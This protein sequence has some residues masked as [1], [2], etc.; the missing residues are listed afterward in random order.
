MI[1]LWR[2]E[3]LIWGLFFPLFQI[4][5][6][7][8]KNL[9]ERY[10]QEIALNNSVRLEE[11]E[12]TIQISSE[13]E[14]EQAM[15]LLENLLTR[16]KKVQLMISSSSVLKKA[17]AL[18]EKYPELDLKMVPLVSYFWQKTP[19][20]SN[21]S[22]FLSP[23]HLILCRYDFF[24]FLMLW[25]AKPSVK[26]SLISASLKGK[27]MNF[28]GGMSKLYWN[29]LYSFF[30]FII[31]ASPQ[32]QKRFCDLI[33]S[34]QGADFDFRQLR[35]LS[36]LDQAPLKLG[37]WKGLKVFQSYLDQFKKENRIIL[38]S[39]WSEECSVLQNP[40]FLKD[41]GLRKCCLV[42]APHKLNDE[43]ILKLKQ[44]IYTYC[45]AYEEKISVEEIGE[46]PLTGQPLKAPVIIV[47]K[48]GILV[49][50]YQYFAHAYIGG[51][52]G[53]SIHSVLEPFLAGCRVYCGPKTHRST[54][55]DLV[56]SHGDD[57]IQVIQDPSYFY[58]FYLKNKTVNISKKE[59]LISHLKQ[60]EVIH[61]KRLIG[62]A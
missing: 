29:S 1:I 8:F 3:L 21:P 28:L 5:R 35:I 23:H 10:S 52:H 44:R 34:F 62:E 11:N 31:P 48:P 36:R 20:S 51:G 56:S 30:D 58:D 12:M 45:A 53:R 50:L 6:V 24:P 7:F 17:K 14:L 42:I 15:S 57:K 2:L 18:S 59:G 9:N 40:A 39:C 46:F 54:E 22:S 16:G 27:K 33:P 41:L 49:E 25:G 4:L 26:F 43:E 19:L 13:G 61:F 55:F 47:R 37:C 38:G 60:Q 32:E